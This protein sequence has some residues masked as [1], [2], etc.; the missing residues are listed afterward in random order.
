MEL[1][2][3]LVVTFSQYLLDSGE[4][5]DFLDQG[6]SLLVIHTAGTGDEHIQIA[7]GFATPAQGTGGGNGVDSF[8]VLQ[9]FSQPRGRAVSLVNEKT[10]GDAAIIFDRLE[11]LLFALFAHARKGLQLA[12]LSQF[13]HA[14]K[15]TD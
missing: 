7:D 14:C 9:V 3:D 2:A 6:R 1:E 15:V 11:D 10:S 12:L 5:C 4:V 8:D 13:L